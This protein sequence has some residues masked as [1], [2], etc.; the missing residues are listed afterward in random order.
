MDGEDLTAKE[1]AELWGGEVLGLNSNIRIYRYREGQF[2]DRHYDEEN[3]VTFEDGKGG[4]KIKGRTTW[5]LLVYLSGRETGCE[6]GETVFWP[7]ED[8]A[9]GFGKG[10]GENG[11]GQGEVVAEMEVGLALL[12]RHGRECLLHEGREVKRGEK[13]VIRSDLVVRR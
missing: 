4:E 13:W 9:G 3:L 11:D 12:H 10:R 7:D 1:R 8:S 6:G 5:T 2:F